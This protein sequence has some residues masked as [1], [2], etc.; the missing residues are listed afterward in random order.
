M[1]RAK[2]LTHKQVREGKLGDQE[3][4]IRSGDQRGGNTEPL[5]RL[6]KR[7]TGAERNLTV[8]SPD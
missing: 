3:T 7:T 1:A 4:R 6:H 2:R 5:K 8:R